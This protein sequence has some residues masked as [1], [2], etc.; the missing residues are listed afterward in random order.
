MEDRKK[1][2]KKTKIVID[3]LIY[4]YYLNIKRKKKIVDKGKEIMTRNFNRLLIV[5]E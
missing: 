4:F 2:K 5:E 1:N 3:F